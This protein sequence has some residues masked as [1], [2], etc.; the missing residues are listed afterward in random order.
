[1]R[2]FRRSDSVVRHSAAN[3]SISRTEKQRDVDG[4]RFSPPAPS[5]DL[6]RA[7]VRFE[8]ASTRRRCRRR[9]EVVERQTILFLLDTLPLGFCDRASFRA[10]LAFGEMRDCASLF[11]VLTPSLGRRRA[12]RRRRLL[13][14]ARRSDCSLLTSR[15]NSRV[16]PSKK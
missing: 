1:M 6:G 14:L 2:C 8:C 7:T 10:V 13:I 9:G 5:L 12:F 16:Q 11:R 3:R 4:V 15:P